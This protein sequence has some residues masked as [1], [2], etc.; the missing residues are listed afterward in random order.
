MSPFLPP[1]AVRHCDRRLARGLFFV[2][3]A[4]YTAVF[5]GVPENPDSEVEYQTTSSLARTGSF[6]IGGTP[7]G[8]AL[9][10][11]GHGL[12]PGGP[13][14]EGRFYSW[15]G[16]G[17][18]VAGLP[19]WWVGHGLALLFPSIEEAHRATTHYGVGRS[20]YFEHLLVGWRNAL[21]TAM[22]AW[23]VVLASRRVGASGRSAFL[24]GL[25]YGL[26]T[27]ALPQARSTLNDVQATFSLFLA[28]HLLLRAREDFARGRT[29]GPLVVGG[30]GFALGMAFLTR[31]AVSL[32]VGFLG[33]VAVAVLVRSGKGEPRGRT[34]RRL[35]WLAVPFLACAGFFLWSNVTRFGDPLETGYGT[36]FAG[37]NFFSPLRMV[38]GFRDLLVAPGKGLVFLAPGLLLLPFGIAR[39]RSRGEK[40]WPWTCAGVALLVMAPVA[41]IDSWHGAWTYGPRYVLPA[42]PFA[43][44][45]VALAL[46]LFAS[47]DRPVARAVA[48]GVVGFG[49][50]TNL[51]GV[52]VDYTTHQDLAVQAAAVAWPEETRLPGEPDADFE[53]RRFGNIQRSWSFA[54]PWAHWRIFRHRVSGRGEHF[55]LRTLFFLDV[56]D[57]VTPRHP[58]AEGM[59]HVAWLDFRERLGGP[60]WP[61][62][63]LCLAL[64]VCGLVWAARGLEDPS[65]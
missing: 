34:V 29:P 38:L 50:V 14:R 20:E 39:A 17:Q 15:F 33:V 47:E 8:D 21:L 22:T 65:L 64:F 5:T 30:I 26:A 46:D 12:A 55:P 25:T 27:Y 11:D 24:A 16:T 2:L 36:A 23:M 32:G 48:L 1:S 41:M 60:I 10:A 54:A 18:A 42:L 31:V 37:G 57:T 40:L 61:A 44:L 58:R 28:F 19:F 7:E 63:L 35:A 4:L 13:G 56:D 3:L 52:L 49:L 6:A 62:V 45:G 53:A 59:R 43:W 9:L 51:P